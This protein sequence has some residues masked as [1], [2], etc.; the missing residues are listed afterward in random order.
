MSTTDYTKPEL[1]C[2]AG[3][4]PALKAA[5]DAGGDTV[6]L[7]FRNA[8][9]ARNFEGLN[10]SCE[11]AEEGIRYAHSR[12]AQV[13]VAVNTSPGPRN[14][15][16]WTS[17]VDMAAELGAD[18]VIISDIALLAYAKEKHPN[19][20]RH[21]SVQASAGNYE[22]LEF[23]ARE[24]GIRRAV[25]PRILTLD[26]IREI[27]SKSSLEIEIFASGGLCVMAEG[28]CWLSSYVTGDSPN[29]HGVCSPA[30]AVR[31][32]EENDR[33]DVKLD[34]MLINRFAPGEAAAYPTLC[35]G[36]FEA[37]G[38]QGHVMEAPYSLNVLEML[39]EIFAA[40]VQGLKIEGRQ[41]NKHYV[42]T[43]VSTWRAAVDACAGDPD[44][45]AVQKEWMTSLA[46]TSE[47]GAH[48]TGAYEDAWR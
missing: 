45:Y 26:A 13:F 32:E 1:V 7:G 3:N 27:C 44:G 24:F 38:K 25:L 35:K 14:A 10:F 47:G 20:R 41:R 21:L 37:A 34:G 23:Y 29:M 15:A 33:L 11:E 4:L 17:S 22:A 18:A 31:F 19:L 16:D 39:P 40:G 9:N 2:P 8:S 12:N 30:H 48:T 46:A 28:R 36:R 43:V 6:Y 5:V 42:R